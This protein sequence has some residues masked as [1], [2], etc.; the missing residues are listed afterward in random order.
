VTQR[1]RVGGRSA[2]RGAASARI[3]ALMTL[4]VDGYNVIHAWAALQ[5]VLRERGMDDAR[6]DLVRMLGEYAAQNGDAVTVVFDAHARTRDAS[7]PEVIDGVTVL[8]G[9]RTASADHVIERLAN[10]AARRKQHQ[11]V[12][13]ATGDR[14]QRSLVGAMGVAT[15]T[16]AQLEA[17]VARVAAGV[18]DTARRRS[19]DTGHARRVEHRLDDATRRRL[20]QLRRGGG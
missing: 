12:T 19:A 3:H 5:L 7:P 20:E 11:G 17:E 15:I 16:P 10:E 2:V 9:T 4:I 8:F 18:S 1:G 13:V 14:L 6:R